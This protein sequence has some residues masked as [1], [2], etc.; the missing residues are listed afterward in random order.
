MRKAT[1]TLGGV[2]G[3]AAIG[4]VAFSAF[5]SRLAGILRA[6][7]LS[8]EEAQIIAQEIRDGAVVDDLAARILEPIARDDLIARGPGL[9]EAQSYAFAVMGVMSAALYLVAAV[10]MIAYLRRMRS[11]ATL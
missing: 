3:G 2:L 9:L 11:V 8:F 1:S 7:G 10:V 4:F 6:D 5:Q